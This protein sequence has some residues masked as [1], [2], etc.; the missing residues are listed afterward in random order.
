MNK[1]GIV[2]LVLILNQVMGLK[3]LSGQ[4]KGLLILN[5]L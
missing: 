4:Q 3:I 2:Y 1:L 5:L